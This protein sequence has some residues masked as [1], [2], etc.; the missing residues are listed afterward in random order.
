MLF[1]RTRTGLVVRC[2]VLCSLLS[3]CGRDASEP[4]GGIALVRPIVRYSP[5]AL[6][7]GN[8]SVDE[9]VIRV[10]RADESTALQ[11]T[12]SFP[13]DQTTLTTTLSVPLESNPETV[14]IDITLL[15]QGTLLFSGGSSVDLVPGEQTQ[16]PTITLT[17][18]GPGANIATLSL[19]PTDTTIFVGDSFTYDLTARDAAGVAVAL[20]YATWQ[21]TSN[22]GL[23]IDANGRIR[24][25]SAGSALVS[26][27]TPQPLSS[28]FANVRVLPLPGTVTRVS[29]DNQIWFPGDTLPAVIE[30]EVRQSNGTP[31][32]DAP[33]AWA[34]VSGGGAFAGSRTGTPSP[35][36]ETITD[37]NG[38]SR[39]APILGPTPGANSYRATVGTVTTTF[40]AQGQIADNIIFGGDTASGLGIRSTYFTTSTGSVSPVLVG[41]GNITPRWSPNRRRVA[42]FGG[43]P[44]GTFFI[45]PTLKVVD[46]PAGTGAAIVTDTPAVSPRWNPTGTDL[47]FGCGTNDVCIIRGLASQTAPLVNGIGDGAGKI[48]LSDVALGPTSSGSRAFAWDPADAN[49]VVLARN[50]VLGSGITS[51]LILVRSDGAAYSALSGQLADGPDP[52]AVGDIDWAPNGAFVVFTAKTLSGTPRLYR[53]NRDGTGLTRLTT[54]PAGLSDVRPVIS[55]GSGEI[56]FVRGDF[57]NGVV[58]ADYFVMS[59]TGGGLRQLSSEGAALAG[60]GPEPLIDWSP[61]GND[62]VLVGSGVTGTAVYRVPQSVTSA[63]YPTSRVLVSRAAGTVAD[64]YPSWRP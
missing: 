1:R 22:N 13:P 50:I 41:G 53:I 32:I 7:V 58:S 47:A 17:Y 46:I 36:I 54:P 25:L 48:F 62:L 3:A 11:R 57:S 26:A 21:L 59:S 37:V 10:T 56:A 5:Q 2:L 8:V 35:T 42:V 45:P 51:V 23:S 14:F 64:F 63:T 16:A 49:T 29:G 60:T 9:V 12:E 55:P 44:S 27:S 18:F 30:I 40:A 28:N 33:V 20:F 43:P 39:V 52:I 38:R 19:T 15:G 6:Q 31:L 4:S 61:N 24:A 34:M